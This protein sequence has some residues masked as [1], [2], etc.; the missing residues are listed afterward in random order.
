MKKQVTITP[1]VLITIGLISLLTLIISL[2]N[3]TVKQ[4][5]EQKA[6]VVYEITDPYSETKV[7]EYLL[8]LKIKY[9]LVAMA[10]M[11]LESANATSNIF[12]QNN[13][14]FGMKEPGLRPTTAL[15]TKNNHAYYAHWRQ[16]V[17]DY[18]IWQAY[19]MNAEN[20]Q[21]KEAWLAYINRFY[22]E[23]PGEY[24]KRILAIESKLAYH[25]SL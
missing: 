11:K 2:I 9:P 8:Q 3:M 20:I 23:I 25:K 13:N 22:S 7:Y 24:M 17:L 1:T 12:K 21:S 19:V 6:T 4:P 15:G 5:T 10:Q 16:S 18:A 14:V